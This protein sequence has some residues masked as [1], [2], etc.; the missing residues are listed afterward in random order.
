MRFYLFLASFLLFIGSAAAEYRV[1]TLHIE[2]QKD[3]SIRQL[4]TTLDPE[5]FTSL[6]PLPAHEKISYTQTWRCRGRTDFFK[7]HCEN[8]ALRRLAEPALDRNPASQP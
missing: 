4:D 7:G 3:Q 5:Q 6:Y 8:P 2:N 1:F